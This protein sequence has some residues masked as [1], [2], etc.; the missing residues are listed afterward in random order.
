MP[1]FVRVRLDNGAHKTIPK[2]VAVAAGLKPL[3]QEPLAQD[4]RLARTKHR[5]TKSGAA[6][7]NTTTSEAD[8]SESKED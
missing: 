1:E 4:G 8:A 6:V 5:V 7:A 2:A 3:K